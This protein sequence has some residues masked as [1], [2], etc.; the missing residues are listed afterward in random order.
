MR[1]SEQRADS[2]PVRNLLWHD[3][4]TQDTYAAL[5]RRTTSSTPT[6]PNV[7]SPRSRLP[8]GIPKRKQTN[9]RVARFAAVS[10]RTELLHFTRQLPGASS[11]NRTVPR[12][13]TKSFRWI[14]CPAV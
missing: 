2:H 1:E 10:G 13:Q 8:R 7:V 12:R 3:G 6:F 4:A 5:A 14:T 9:G 11:S